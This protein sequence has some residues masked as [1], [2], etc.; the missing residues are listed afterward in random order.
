MPRSRPPLHNGLA[1]IVAVGILGVLAVLA[2]CFV[3]MAHLERQA[4]QRRTHAT[5]ALLLARSGIED[6]LARLSSGQDPSTLSNRWMNEAH[7]AFFSEALG[8]FPVDGRR[9]GASGLLS[10]PGHLFSLKVEDESAKINVNGGFLDAGDRDNGVGDGIPDHRDADVRASPPGNDPGRGW[11]RQLARIL[12]VLGAQM[13]LPNLGTD[14]LTRRPP[15]GWPSIT[16][17]Q[18]ELGT[19]TN[20]SPYLTTRSWSD[21]RVIHPNTFG[22]EFDQKLQRRALL[23]EEGGRS[24][25]NLNAAPRP[26]LV[27]LL[28]GLRGLLYRPTGRIYDLNQSPMARFAVEI[29]PA[30]AS[31]VA[32]ALMARREVRPFATWTEFDAFL[33]GLVLSGAFSGIEPP[34]LG[35]DYRE[36]WSGCLGADL[37]RAAFNPN[38]LL[39]EQLPDQV[40]WH[41][42][43]KADLLASSTEGS[44]GATG[45]FRLASTG[46]VL[47]PQ[48]RLL[49]RAEASA[50]AELFSLLRQSTQK[51][52]VAGRAYLKDYLER[53]WANASPLPQ[54]RCTGASAGVPWWGGPPPKV[55]G[56]KVGVTVMT[57][58]CSP[59]ALPGNAADFDGYVSLAT[60]ETAPLNP[61]GGT[62]TFL[63]H[64]DDGW[65]ADLSGGKP[66]LNTGPW[67]GGV[68]K[69]PH[70]QPDPAQSVWPGT[71]IE[72][73]TLLP[74]GMR[75]E[76]ERCPSYLASGNVPADSAPPVSDHGV[77]S[78]WVKA[79]ALNP[80]YTSYEFTC[81]RVSGSVTQFLGTGLHGGEAMNTLNA[82]MLVEHWTG[83]DWDGANFV[84]EHGTAKDR[85]LRSPD[86]RWCLVTAFFD[87]DE[88][89][90]GLDVAYSVKGAIPVAGTAPYGFG[91]P[92]APFPTATGEKLFAA[93]Q[94]FTLGGPDLFEGYR[95]ESINHTADDLLDEFAICDFTD[96]AITA[97]GKSDAWA[98]QRYNDGR[99]CKGEPGPGVREAGAFLSG[100][101]ASPFGGDL[102]L[103]SVRWSEHLPTDP[104]LLTSPLGGTTSARLIDPLL[105][106]PSG[107]SRLWMELELTDEA[108]NLLQPLE[109]GASIS[110]TL[111]DFRYRVRFKTDVDRSRPVLETPF[112][113]DI[114][115]AWQ[116]ASGPRILGWGE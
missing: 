38:T 82:G 110:R 83:S 46:R 53:D 75:G 44:L 66:A 40:L 19:T 60:L 111:A 6:A 14:V 81:T 96:V 42:V 45:I 11:N 50:P 92:F 5:R 37:I 23:L 47:D 73:S 54:D 70:H 114:T 57:H 101:L 108:G 29:S 69:N 99:Y 104:K 9:V 97:V 63:H 26:V 31:T 32:D 28:Q 87:T 8:D 106:D 102:R 64:F 27:A 33:D 74:D 24:P 61:D 15:G 10:D 100:T 13:A 115:F 2:T 98:F 43:D 91:A 18:S 36:S 20:L 39:N 25:V 84:H 35:T 56:Q 93:G 17:L 94:I 113:D 77:L 59:R 4:S 16:A 7:P 86:A 67:F 78:Y 76:W 22:N 116:H 62:L 68:N 34:W 1:L 105:V 51:D 41:W 85:N 71:P 52:F 88:T 49:A 79:P 58:P 21:V 95:I 30:M 72:P 80:Q 3:T 89:V 107:K 12:N 112:F 48:G 65:E 109:Q 103:L 90:D 55:A